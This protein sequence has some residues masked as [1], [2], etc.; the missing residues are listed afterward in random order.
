MPVC[1]T[2]FNW[3]VKQVEETHVKPGWVMLKIF[4]G[5]SGPRRQKDTLV[6][7]Q[8]WIDTA[9]PAH[10]PVQVFVIENGTQC[11]SPLDNNVNSRSLCFV[12]VC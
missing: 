9:L 4:Y 2:G 8:V 12:S 6:Q 11:I 5:S 1:Q 10:P 7:T 3:L